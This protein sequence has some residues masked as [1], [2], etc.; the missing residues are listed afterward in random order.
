M[1]KNKSVS[2]ILFFFKCVPSPTRIKDYC[3]ATGRSPLACG[4]RKIRLTSSRSRCLRAVRGSAGWCIGTCDGGLRDWTPGP[5]VRVICSQWMATPQEEERCAQS[6][7]IIGAF[8]SR[9]KSLPGKGLGDSREDRAG[10]T[11]HPGGGHLELC[12]RTSHYCPRPL[13]HLAH[14]NAHLC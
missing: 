10:F 5:G 8:C 7:H 12:P 13:R 11:A 2:P 3:A 14:N 9:C 4:F 6:H 1:K